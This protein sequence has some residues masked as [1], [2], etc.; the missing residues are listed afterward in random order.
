MEL[1]VAFSNFRTGNYFSIQLLVLSTF[2]N[3]IPHLCYLLEVY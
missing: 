2:K 1:L 3:K